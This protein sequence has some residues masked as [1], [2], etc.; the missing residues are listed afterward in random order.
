MGGPGR[1]CRRIRPQAAAPLN[2]EA[3]RMELPLPVGAQP[4]AVSSREKGEGRPRRAEVGLGWA[5]E[6][7]GGERGRC[8]VARRPTQAGEG[9][10]AGDDAWGTG[11]GGRG[12]AES[13]RPLTS[14]RILSRVWR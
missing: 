10:G 7:G 11:E 14:A 6:R 12:A 4:L 13:R 3:A 2:P 5:A 8:G 9:A 1:P